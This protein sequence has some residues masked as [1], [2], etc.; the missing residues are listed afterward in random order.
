MGFD[1]ESYIHELLDM[2]PRQLEAEKNRLNRE[3][4]SCTT[5]QYK[6]AFT[7]FLT[8]P[9]GIY[10]TVKYGCHGI[11][12][13]HKRDIVDAVMKE[14]GTYSHSRKRD[15]GYGAGTAIAMSGMGSLA[16]DMAEDLFGDIDHDH[17]YEWAEKPAAKGM[18]K[19]VEKGGEELV[20]RLFDYE[21]S[22][23]SLAG[24]KICDGCLKVSLSFR[25]YRIDG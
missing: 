1:V 25:R 11:D 5:K 8:G 12:A 6:H 16:G 15:F 20:Q 2:T 3:W 22:H 24:T 9:Y 18:E 10:K 13:A 23:G 4:S 19:I 17:D 14:L 21:N 7:T